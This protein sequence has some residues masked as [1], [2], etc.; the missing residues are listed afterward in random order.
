MRGQRTVNDAAR[1]RQGRGVRRTVSGI[2]LAL[3]LCAV[4]MLWCGSAVTWGAAG[5]GFVSGLREAP[6]GTAL[7]EPAAV[8]VDV[9]DGT[10]FV[11]D[12]GRG[13]VDVFDSSGTY[14]TRFGGGP[15]FVSGIAV[16]EASGDV[17]V[18][19]SFADAVLV[20]KPDGSGGYQLLSE[21]FGE[22]AAGGEFGDVTGVAVDNSHSVSTGDVYVVDGKSL[23]S[24]GGVVDAFSPK[25]E[26]P[27][28]ALEGVL[29]RSLTSGKM[30]QPNGVA[31][32]RSTGRVLVADSIKGAV[33][34]FDAT[35]AL[36]EKMSGKGS[37]YGS[38]KGKEEPGNVAGVA[39]DEASGEIYVAEAERHTVSQY[40]SSGMWE[41]WITTTPDGDLGEPRGVALTP[42]GDVY[43]ADAGLARVDRFGPAVVVPGVE[44]GIVAKSGLTRTSA[45][46]PGIVNG[47]GKPSSYRFQ[48]GESEQLGSQTSSQAAGTAEQAVSATVEGLQAGHAY[49]Y[50]I[51][52]E[53][54]DGAGYGLIRR[55]E[56]LPAV[57]ALTTGPV[58][59]LLAEGAT[60][61]GSLKRGGLVTHYYFQYGTSSSYGKQAPQPSAEMPPASEEKEEKL[62]RPVQSTV[63]GLEANTLYHYR[64]VAENSFGTTYGQ[65]LTFTTSG[66]PRISIEPVSGAGQ[67]EATLHAQVN[68][69]QLASTYRFQYGESAGYGQETTSNSA[70]SGSTPQSVSAVLSSLSVGTTYHYRIVAENE[71]GTTTGPDEV[72][73]TVPSAPVDSTYA[74]G[75]TATEAVLRAQINPLGNDTHY[76]FQYGTQPCQSSPAACTDIPAPPGEDIGSGTEDA[77]GEAKLS[78]L[79][80]GTVYH[81]R[82]ID[83]NSLG[84]TEGPEQTFTTQAEA[85]S[86][87]LPDARAWEMVTPPDK[88][89]APV[90]ALTREG[91]IILASEDGNLLTYVVDGAFGEEVKGNRSPEMQQFLATRTDNGW[92]SQDIANPNTKAKGITAGEAPEYQFF[93][94]DLS[95]GLVKPVGQGAEPPLAEGVTQATIY[96][97]DNATG[98]YLPLVSETNVAPGVNFSGKVHF[99][100]ATTDLTH[101]VFYSAAGLTG[102]RSRPGLYEWSAGKLQFVSVLPGG[103]PAQKAELGYLHDPAN[104]IS[105]NGSRVVWTVPAGAAEASRGHLYLRDTS[106]GE[107]V[108]LDAAHGVAEPEEGSA[109]YQTASSDGSRVFFTDKR[110]LTPDSTAEPAPG[111]EA[112]DL[113]ECQLVEEDG[114]LT[115]R[116]SDLTVDQ[117]SGEH[118]AVQGLV[119]GASQDGTSV[120]AVAQGVLAG[121]VNGNGEAAQA[122]ADNLYEWR[123]AGGQWATTFIA[124]L[125]SADKA[126]WEGAKLADTA[127]LTARISPNGRYLAFMSSAPITGYDNVDANGAANGARDE[128]V[129]LYD[130][131]TASL[132]CV[133]CNP[134]GARPSGVLDTVQSGEG[135]GLLVDRREVWVGRWLAGNIPGWT[136]QSLPV[137]EQ[138]GALFQ[139]R[140]LSDE[141]RLYFNSPDSLVPAATNGKEDVYEYEP[142][143]IGSC[144]SVTGGCVSLIS[145]GEST[146]ETAFLEATPDGSSV[147]FLTEAQL[148]S[149]DTDTAFDIYAAREC[150]QV[151]PCLIPPES[152]PQGCD[153]TNTCRPAQPAQQIPGLVPATTNL[154]T[155]GNL[156]TKTPLP[157][158]QEVGAKRVVKPLTRAQ[159]LKLALKSCHKRYAHSKKRRSACERRARKR[160]AVNKHGSQRAHAQHNAKG[161][162]SISADGT[163]RKGVQR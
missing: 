127:Y 17:Y 31:V 112:S 42:A 82:I 21:W 143:G 156:T 91:G 57:E 33:Y 38:F 110:R 103:R 41:G 129:F 139:S 73:T 150:S 131:D 15:L 59:S 149:Q 89:G 23:A 22:H 136:A 148:L 40:S 109:Q 158:K 146:H 141:G 29:V 7:A 43:V 117:N 114:K 48:Y 56:T 69:D 126:E 84:T 115:C 161:A 35:G 6:P 97:R 142:A 152:A 27:E 53:D 90:E 45:L 104:A 102:G 37:P 108:Q 18:A 81:Y 2:A 36:E 113:Y 118:A 78:G 61:T 68:P 151:S 95:L 1:M 137:P 54:E 144:Q 28:E 157:P 5:H 66:P 74:T 49:Y 154:N 138:P 39:V 163:S 155:S 125:A 96:L 86:F 11:G 147:F 60:L 107:T 106:R 145:G 44:T 92:S 105:T 80:P 65:D 25:P 64:L 76:Y 128:E 9:K 72:F 160:Y 85:A 124:R 13:F 162:G 46:L 34:A 62:A 12:P 133:S 4:W 111:Q 93:S 123:L 75:V 120:Y 47:E 67:H 83:S 30:E 121:N 58:T 51:L 140:Y 14:V 100:S 16:D 63:T 8:A 70:G 32:S 101:V 119:L 19:D 94:S 116:L 132:R 26:G 77:Q 87:A 159:R 99:I 50:R 135:L 98:T 153:A 55:F 88:G 10:V 130:S 71:A 3:L 79:I 20:F 52:A 134:S 24:G 122:G